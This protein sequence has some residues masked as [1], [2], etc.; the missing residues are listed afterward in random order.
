MIPEGYSRSDNIITSFNWVVLYV[1][2]FLGWL[3]DLLVEP[4]LYLFTSGNGEILKSRKNEDDSRHLSR[5][6][7]SKNDRHGP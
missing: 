1:R 2:A 3:S 7:L 4:S 6:L 5:R